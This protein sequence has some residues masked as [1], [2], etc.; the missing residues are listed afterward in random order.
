MSLIRSLLDLDN[1][2]FWISQVGYEGRFTS[3]HLPL[4][5]PIPD[6]DRDEVQ[7]LQLLLVRRILRHQAVLHQGLE[8]DE[9]LAVHRRCLPNG[10]LVDPDVPGPRHSP[11]LQESADRQLHAAPQE[12]RHDSQTRPRD[13][14]GDFQAKEHRRRREPGWPLR[15]RQLRQDQQQH[16]RDFPHQELAERFQGSGGPQNHAVHQA[17]DGR[18]PA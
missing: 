7:H 10:H 1:H 4:V 14:D 13:A 9:L 2:N 3:T 11:T 12:R 16:P 15:V 5:P 18:A 8:L 6:P 17:N